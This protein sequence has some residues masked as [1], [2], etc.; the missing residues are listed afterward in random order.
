MRIAD[1]GRRNPSLF[2]G[3]DIGP[4]RLD[5]CWLDA[6]AP[7]RHEVLAAGHR[8]DEAVVLGAR[9][10]PQ[11]EGTEVR[12]RVRHVLAMTPGAV[13]RIDRRPRLNLLRREGLQIL[14]G[15]WTPRNDKH[16]NDDNKKAYAVHT[17][18]LRSHVV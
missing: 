16:A 15:Q 5:L 10:L 11:I 13:L 6:V 14:R 18:P 12:V 1:C 7:S 8:A 17:T 3:A 4:Q 2:A 9:E